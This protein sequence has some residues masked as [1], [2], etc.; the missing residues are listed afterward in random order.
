MKSRVQ[1]IIKLTHTTIQIALLSKEQT[2]PA[3]ESTIVGASRPE[4][5]MDQTLFLLQCISIYLHHP[6]THLRRATDGNLGNK[7]TLD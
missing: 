4:F 6:L 7:Q 2:T 5:Q 1:H 3:V